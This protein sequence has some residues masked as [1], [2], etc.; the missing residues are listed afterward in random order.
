MRFMAEIVFKLDF[1]VS[2]EDKGATRVHIFDLIYYS[3]SLISFKTRTSRHTKEE[4]NGHT[5]V[6]FLSGD[7]PGRVKLHLNFD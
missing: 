4:R 2:T 6:N 7:F 5:L 3:H 1:T